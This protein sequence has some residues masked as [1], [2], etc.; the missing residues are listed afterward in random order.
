MKKAILLSFTALAAFVLSLD[1][2]EGA[3]DFFDILDQTTAEYLMSDKKNLQRS[4]G[5]AI[6]PPRNNKYLEASIQIIR[7]KIVTGR[8][9]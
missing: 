3:G 7:G 2:S 5:A 8:S 9:V 1:F 6:S 4:S